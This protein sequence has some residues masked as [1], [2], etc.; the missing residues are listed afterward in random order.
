MW[1]HTLVHGQN[2]AQH[3]RTKQ[4]HLEPRSDSE[5]AG[6]S[7]AHGGSRSGLHKSGSDQC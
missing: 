3:R 5:T 4:L 6:D 2:P 1:M 7:S